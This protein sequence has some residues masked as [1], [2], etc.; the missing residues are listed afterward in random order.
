M[1]MMTATNKVLAAR[2]S[3][4]AKGS[5]GLTRNAANCVFVAC[6]FSPSLATAREAIEAIELPDVRAASLKLLGELA[7]DHDAAALS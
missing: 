3:E 1:S 6:T 2:A 7:N 4:I 5:D